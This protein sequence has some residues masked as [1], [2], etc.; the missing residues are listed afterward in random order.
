MAVILPNTT[1]TARVRAQHPM[2][3]DARGRA[4]ARPTETWTTHGPNPGAVTE[5]DG[6]DGPNGGP[7]RLRAD[8]SLPDLRP[9]DTLTDATGRVF[10]IREAKRVAVPGASDVDFI[11]VLA[12]LE[13]PR[14]L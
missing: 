10:V 13:P 12:D 3:R 5:P 8:P 7:W 6:Q 4:V 1:L 11:R 2:E 9:L 14:T